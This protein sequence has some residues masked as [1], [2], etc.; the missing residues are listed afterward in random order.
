M[1]LCEL[2]CTCM[3]ALLAQLALLLPYPIRIEDLLGVL[4]GEWGGGGGGG[5]GS[6]NE[7]YGSS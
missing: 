7:S 1:N 4:H 5:G 6:L 3:H 2:V